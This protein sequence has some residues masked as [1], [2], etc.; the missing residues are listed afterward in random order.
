M[1]VTVGANAKGAVV[2]ALGGAHDEIALAAIARTLDGAVFPGQPA[3]SEV[4]GNGGGFPLIEFTST[5][6]FDP[7][8]SP[9]VELDT[10]RLC[11]DLMAGG[12]T[13][14]VV[15][16]SL[17][18]VA[19]ESAIVPGESSDSIWDV[20]SCEAAPHGAV[21]LNPNPHRFWF[22]LLLVLIVVAANVALAV[23][24]SRGLNVPRWMTIGLSGTAVAVFL[25]A[26][27]TAGFSAGND[28]EV[29]GRISHAANLFYFAISAIVVLL[30]PIAAVA[31]PFYWRL[32]REQRPR[33]RRRPAGSGTGAGD[34]VTPAS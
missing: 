5:G 22:E 21:V 17:P 9:T 2:L 13:D 12:F 23:I 8:D 3:T 29:A 4:T 7:G 15:R 6:V 19:H 1:S 14:L 11:D 32:P 33:L 10:R 24:G 20:R 31:Q 18:R 27:A 30:G 25:V 28:M 16:L 26:I 34:G